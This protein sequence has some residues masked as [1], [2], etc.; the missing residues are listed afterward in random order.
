MLEVS[1]ESTSGNGNLNL[2]PVL[3]EH[4]GNYICE[5]DNGIGKPLKTIISVFVHGMKKNIIE[6]VYF[7]F[8]QVNYVLE[9]VHI[10]FRNIFYYSFYCFKSI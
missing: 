6:I 2:K 5:A 7:C 3:K 9:I 4:E 8:F 1:S 10:Y